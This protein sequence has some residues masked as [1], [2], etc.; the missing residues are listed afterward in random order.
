MLDNET[1]RPTS[2]LDEG[3][4]NILHGIECLCTYHLRT[5]IQDF[6]IRHHPINAEEQPDVNF[7]RFFWE[8]SFLFFCCS[9]FF[10]NFL[11][12]FIKIHGALHCFHLFYWYSFLLETS[13]NRGPTW[14]DKRKYWS[15][16]GSNYEV[17]RALFY[18]QRSAFIA[19]KTSS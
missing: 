6:V 16:S 7:H 14:A 3:S 5:R 1:S 18:W 9:E 13:F 12:N 10:I 19:T 2:A 15:L 17:I 4:T 11:V 8:S